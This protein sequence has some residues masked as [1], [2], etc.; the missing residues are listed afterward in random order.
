M[1]VP[2]A[3]P[4][5]APQPMFRGGSCDYLYRK[6]YTLSFTPARSAALNC[7]SSGRPLMRRFIV[8]AIGSV[9]AITVN[10]QVATV[11]EI[12]TLVE[13]RQYPE[14]LQKIAAALQLKGPAAKS[15]DRY[16]L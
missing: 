6:G 7:R 15:V 5:V 13:G 11:D 4:A 16:Q 10:A 2:A 9:F 8:A 1:L 14:A 12:R 3:T